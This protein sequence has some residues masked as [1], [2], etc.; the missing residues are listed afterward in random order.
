MIVRS[1]YHTYGMNTVITNCSNN[2]G[3]KQHNEKLI[4]TII[5]KAVNGE[6]IPIYGDC[7]F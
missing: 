3:P 5:R 4:P 2:Y 7:L 1:Y 6:N